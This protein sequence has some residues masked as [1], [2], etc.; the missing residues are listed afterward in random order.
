MTILNLPDHFQISS[1]LYNLSL[2][3]VAEVINIGEHIYFNGLSLYKNEEHDNHKTIFNNRLEEIRIS[4]DKQIKDHTESVISQYQ[5]MIDVKDEVIVSKS[6]E[7]I[8]MKNRISILEQENCQ[9]LS[10]SGKLDSLMG[11]GNT[12]DNAMKGDFGES[13]V[14]NQIQH[15]YQ[16]SEIEDKSADTAKGDLLWKLND[17]EFRALVEVKNVQMVRP[18]EVQ[19]FERDMLINT[20]DKSCNCG[21]FISLKTETIPNKGK[22]KLEFLN[23]FPVIYVSNILDDL[24]TL[25]FALDA[26]CSIQNKYKHVYEDNNDSEDD[27]NIEEI[28][29][30]FVQ[31]QFNKLELM[32]GNINQMKVSVEILSNCITNEENIIRDL[33]NNIIVLK[34]DHDIFKKIESEYKINSKEE[35]KESILKDMRLFKKDNGRMPQMSDLSHKYKSNIFR[36]D[37]AFKKLKK[38]I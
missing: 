29:I 16:A 35:L 34:S 5:K 4:T 8:N 11:K 20:K 12:V 25:R 28:M 9:A 13:I 6:D 19:K 38:E 14:A 33:Y 22:F 10:L 2:N 23:N 18:T 30:E 31:K 17:G 27:L 1:R 15:W 32:K 7:I 24:E 26:L 3:E 37:L 36:D 21:I